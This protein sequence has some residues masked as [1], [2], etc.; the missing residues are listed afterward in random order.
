MTYQGRLTDNSPQQVPVDG[1]VEMAFS[2]WDAD[3][4]GSLL[5]SE[6]SSGTVTV[7]PVKGVF[8]VLLGSYGVP[9]P[10]SVFAGGVV[11]YLEIT[12]GGETL[13]PRQRI[14]TVGFAAQA[15]RSADTDKLG[16]QV[17][18]SNGRCAWTAARRGHGDGV[19]QRQRRRDLQQHPGRAGTAARRSTASGA[20]QSSYTLI[21]AHPNRQRPRQQP[22]PDRYERHGRLSG[23]GRT[24]PWCGRRHLA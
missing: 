3:T 16:G 21:P 15:E 4:G 13:A 22:R 8:N 18:L 23:G 10:P 1:T 5:W 6:P 2:I 7:Y 9:L 20:S 19:D 17:P 14:G 24:P 11:R 12:V